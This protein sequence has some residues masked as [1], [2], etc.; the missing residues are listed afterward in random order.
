MLETT[1]DNTIKEHVLRPAIPEIARP[2]QD[3]VTFQDLSLSEHDQS[4]RVARLRDAYFKACPE[5]CIERPVLVTRLHQELAIFH[6]DRYSILDK[7]RVYR[8]VLERREPIVWHREAK[9]RQGQPFTFDGNSLLAGSTTTKYKGVLLYPEFLALA[10][11]PEL[12]TMSRRAANP[13]Q[14]TPHEAG[15]LNRDVFPV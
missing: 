12:D 7:A 4:A 1:S 11:W 10:L 3:A 6:K 14:I 5:V 15:V 9:D 8:R 2:A 13:Y